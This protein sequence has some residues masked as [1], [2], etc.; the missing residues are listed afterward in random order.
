MRVAPKQ[1]RK[2]V[3]DGNRVS[4]EGNSYAG[5]WPCFDYPDQPKESQAAKDRRAA[6]MVKIAGM[7]EK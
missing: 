4:S 3:Q 7:L 5:N 6:A 1:F 2:I